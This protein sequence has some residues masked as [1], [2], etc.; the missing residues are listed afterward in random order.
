MWLFRATAPIRWLGYPLTSMGYFCIIVFG[1][2]NPIGWVPFQLG[3]ALRGLGD[4]LSAFGSES[5]INDVESWSQER[6]GA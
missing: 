6:T 4:A 1:D 5:H 2:T 3:R